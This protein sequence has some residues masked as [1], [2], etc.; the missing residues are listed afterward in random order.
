MAEAMADP[1]HSDHTEH[2]DV[3]LANVDTDNIDLI[4]FDDDFD[5]TN[6][7]QPAGI[8][9]TT[10]NTQ[11]VGVATE[12][13]SVAD[14]G[15][16]ATEFDE[17]TF[18]E[19][20][21][22]P[23]EGKSIDA[24]AAET[25][26]QNLE[27]FDEI[28][29]EGYE[30]ED[31]GTGAYG[32]EPLQ[33]VGEVEAL[34]HN[35]E[36]QAGA[37]P[38]LSTAAQPTDD[39]SGAVPEPQPSA[40]L[41]AFTIDGAYDDVDRL[42]DAGGVETVNVGEVDAGAVDI[43]GDMSLEFDDASASYDGEGE[44]DSDRQESP[45][46]ASPPNVQV[47]WADEVC[48]LFKSSE[49][50]EPGSYYLDNVEYIDRPLS[51]FLTRIR[52]SIAEWLNP[53]DELHVRIQELGLDFAETTTGAILEQFTFGQLLGLHNTLAMNDG[54]VPAPG[55]HII[56]TTRPNCSVRIQKLVE[57]ANEGRGLSALQSEQSSSAS[58]DTN[59][60][61]PASEMSSPAKPTLH[62]DTELTSHQHS[63]APSVVENGEDLILGN[64]EAY[65]QTDM[66]VGEAGDETNE[67]V[68]SHYGDE[69]AFAPVNDAYEVEHSTEVP[70]G[71]QFTEG[72]DL[73]GAVEDTDFTVDYHETAGHDADA[74]LQD[75][76]PQ[77][78]QDD[79]ENQI[80]DADYLDFGDDDVQQTDLPEVSGHEQGDPGAT[81]PGVV[82]GGEDGLETTRKVTNQDL[83]D[84]YDIVDYGQD[85]SSVS[86]TLSGEELGQDDQATTT[87][88][89]EL[90]QVSAS[91]EAPHD[92]GAAR[93]DDDLDE[94]DWDD[95]EEDDTSANKAQASTPTS[96]TGK[97]G[98][99]TEDGEGLA[100]EH[101]VKRHRA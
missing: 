72:D 97:R 24:L 5:F 93:K 22:M 31:A 16:H 33:H 19:D 66:D 89:P 32:D 70:E 11:G 96:I 57:A 18:D 50:Q 65:L 48:P 87:V 43:M 54:Q 68:G 47:T 56:L 41:S 7:D 4:G 74:L 17:I 14:T 44:G 26:Q 49:T 85:Q 100:D 28:T 40:D 79:A 12:N 92:P 38:S 78:A 51:A 3:D 34:D 30:A 94:I 64:N 42:Q 45:F 61:E 15:N 84:H 71:L 60:N 29:Y 52:E 77:V 10:P 63:D 2:I 39:G 98:R 95:D 91:V 25:S 23:T 75:H 21:E 88:E 86:N 27:D 81:Q 37:T 69:A 90:A 58:L 83:V 46:A 67:H 73:T 20:D 99:E 80:Q 82:D 53:N 9:D 35:G 59:D 6:T 62:Y 36:S 101:D 1:G 13:D 55:L 76:Q 8:S